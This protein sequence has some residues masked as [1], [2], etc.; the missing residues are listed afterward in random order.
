MDAEPEIIIKNIKSIYP[1]LN[2][3]FIKL[4]LEYAENHTTD[5]IAQL[6]THTTSNVEGS[7]ETIS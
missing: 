1:N 3:Y 4:A 5:D 7:V 6:L 2:E